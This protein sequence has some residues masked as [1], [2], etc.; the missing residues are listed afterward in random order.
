MLCN[1]GFLGGTVWTGGGL[2]NLAFLFL[3]CLWNSCYLGIWDV[4]CVT[5]GG[6]RIGHW[7]PAVLQPVIE[8]KRST[9]TRGSA[10]GVLW[11]V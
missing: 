1:L 7:S 3:A 6:W 9:T 5:L 10:M 8:T 11:V 4:D 2:D